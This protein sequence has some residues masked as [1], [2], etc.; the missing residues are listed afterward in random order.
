MRSNLVRMLDGIG[1]AT[2]LGSNPRHRCGPLMPTLWRPPRRSVTVSFTSSGKNYN[3]APKIER[4]PILN[5]F[6]EEVLAR[7]IAS[8]PDVLVIPLGKQVGEAVARL[9]ARA[10]TRSGRASASVRGKRACGSSVCR[11]TRGACS[12]GGG[13][14][15]GVKC[16]R[17][18]H[19]GSDV[20]QDGIQT[21]PGP[22]PGSIVIVR[23]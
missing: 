9:W 1:L 22:T 8:V 6:V 19:T 23:S 14:G 5:A 2:H 15:E 11:A 17:L 10:W 4:H 21:D 12:I 16:P 20:V 7:D 18:G 3:C 13:M